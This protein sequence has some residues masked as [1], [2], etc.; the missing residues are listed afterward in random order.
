MSNAAGRETQEL[1][2]R[3][4]ERLFALRGIDSVPLREIGEEAGQKNSAV[5]NYYFGGRDGLI[6]AI[7][8]YR[9]EEIEPRR[10]EILQGV[11]ETTRPKTRRRLRGLIEAYVRPLSEQAHG[12]HYLGLIARLQIDFGQAEELVPAAILDDNEDLL[13]HLW[14]ELSGSREVIKSR[15][16]S[17]TLLAIH[18]LATRQ[19]V[20]ER[21]VALSY[22]DLDDETFLT[23][24][25][26]CLEG[27][28]LAPTSVTDDEL[29]ATPTIAR[30]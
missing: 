24:L 14:A 18:S 8:E 6:R 17:M 25:L 16:T 9:A 7:F 28:L 2:I 23:D 27:V 26:D 19:L 5:V 4:A 20:T 13:R 10:R 12:G 30:P 29:L 21:H 22:Q 15:V 1:L 3:T 11:L